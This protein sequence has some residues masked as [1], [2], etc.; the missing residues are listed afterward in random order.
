MREGL[1]V[2]IERESARRLAALLDGSVAL[3]RPWVTGEL[4]LKVFGFVLARKTEHSLKPRSV[5]GVADDRA[6]ATDVMP[7]APLR[8]QNAGGGVDGDNGCEHP[9]S[10]Q[11]GR[12]T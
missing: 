5:R 12:S 8:S 10:R 7:P 4:A 9:C 2:L 1:S 6:P 11:T 3:A